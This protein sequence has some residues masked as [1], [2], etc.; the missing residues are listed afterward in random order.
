MSDL[1]RS[2]SHALDASEQPEQEAMRLL[3]YLM[4]RFGW[5]GTVMTREDAESEAGR[6]LTD[7]EWD[8]VRNTKS[9]R[10]APSIWNE[11]GITWESVRQALDAAGVETR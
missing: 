4:D 5:S 6:E 11:D 8:E 2:V 3:H 10:D 9:W 1:N 7:R